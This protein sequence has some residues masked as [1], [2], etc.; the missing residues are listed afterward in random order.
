MEDTY[1]TTK[2]LDWGFLPNN[3]KVNETENWTEKEGK[4]LI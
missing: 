1:V 3:K 4:V 2:V